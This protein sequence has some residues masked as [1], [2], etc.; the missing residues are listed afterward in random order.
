VQYNGLISD[1]GATARTPPPYE[2][3]ISEKAPG[4]RAVVTHEGNGVVRRYSG[5]KGWQQGRIS[6]DP[7]HQPRD[8]RDSELG[9][10][11]LEDPYFFAGQL[12]QLVTGLHVARVEKIDGKETYVVAGR[13]QALPEVNLYFDR[14]S[15][16]L[17]RIISLTQGLFGRLP[18]Q[19]DYSDF[20][21]V[22][23]VKV[24]FHWVN[25]GHRGR[26]QFHVSGGFR[27]AECSRG[28]NQICQAPCVRAPVS[29]EK[30]TQKRFNPSVN[31]IDAPQ[32][33]VNLALAKSLWR[34]LL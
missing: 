2:V 9:N 26:Q 30:I 6:S 13:T 14:E 32:G 5:D 24:P 22:D 15:G 33:S 4:M 11:K 8:M 7:R 28:G 12:K 3:E 10:T 20:R 25:T 29:V 34:D 1:R 18:V 31:S 19:L 21:D 17:V 27:A 23:G 16:M